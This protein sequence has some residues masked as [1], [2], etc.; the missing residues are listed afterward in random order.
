MITYSVPRREYEVW[1]NTGKDNL[2]IGQKDS[3]AL[4]TDMIKLQLSKCKNVKRLV[5]AVP[6]YL[7]NQQ[8][9]NVRSAASNAVE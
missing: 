7:S 5:L 4:M 8:L 6:A 9:D 1:E 2:A 3:E